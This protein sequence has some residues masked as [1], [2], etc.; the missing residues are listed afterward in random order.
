MTVRGWNDLVDGLAYGAMPEL[1]QRE[2]RRLRLAALVHHPLAAESGLSPD[3]AEALRRSE[4]QALAQ[5]R[6]VLVT[7]QATASIQ[8]PARRCWA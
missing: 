1:A 4:T 7:S 6:L 5:A 8:R 2:G 3:M